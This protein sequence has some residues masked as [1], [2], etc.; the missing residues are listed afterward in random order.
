MRG[1]SAIPISYVCLVFF[2]SAFSNILSKVAMGIFDAAYA[3][4]QH[5]Q[6]QSRLRTDE[7]SLF[8]LSC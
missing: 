6:E 5:R 2:D 3:M 7:V 8:V 4:Y 1:A